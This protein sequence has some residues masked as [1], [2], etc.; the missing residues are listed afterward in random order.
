MQVCAGSL[1]EYWVVPRSGSVYHWKL[2][3]ASGSI[4]STEG[5]D[6]I[7]ILWNQQKGMD[8]LMVQEETQEGCLKN[9][10]QLVV[11][12]YQLQVRILTA[13]SEV[14]STNTGVPIEIEV[15]SKYPARLIVETDGHADTIKN[16]MQPLC[17]Y[18]TPPLKNDAVFQIKRLIDDKG[19]DL[20]LTDKI[21]IT[22]AHRLNTLQIIPAK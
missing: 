6:R 13:A 9:K 5:S 8:T 16:I 22:L 2:A 3:Q 7:K 11:E 18:Q 14:C 21:N 19:C 4:Q 15:Q 17:R 10:S 12:K 20:E 1:S